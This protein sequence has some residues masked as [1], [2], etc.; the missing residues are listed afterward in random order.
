MNTF[1]GVP[2]NTSQFLSWLLLL[3]NIYSRIHKGSRGRV[4]KEA[5]SKS[6]GIF[7]RRF[8]SYR[9]RSI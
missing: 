2:Q 3:D 7:P 9:L 5:D 4:V 8:E 6:A 1:N